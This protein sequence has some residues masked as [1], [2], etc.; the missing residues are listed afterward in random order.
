ML[1]R[2]ALLITLLTVLAVV[3]PASAQLVSLADDLALFSRILTSEQEAR[4]HT[5]LG[6]G[7]GSLESL[8][9][10]LPG[11][12]TPAPLE[13][14]RT[15]A[16]GQ[17]IITPIPSIPGPGSA[18]E[19][20]ALDLPH[21]T[22]DGPADGLTLEQAMERLLQTNY[23]L[24]TRFQELSKADADILTA[25]LR[26]NPLLFASA[27]N[28]PYGSYSPQ[29][30]GEALYSATIIQSLDL[31]NKRENRL[32]VARSARNVLEALYQN[33]VRQE[34]DNLYRA[35]LEVLAA[36]ETLRHRQAGLESL[37]HDLALLA[38][39]QKP[40]EA[41]ESVEMDRV[42]MRRDAAVM[43][44]ESATAVLRQAQQ[45]LAALLN[46]PPEEASCLQVRGRLDP[47]EV[48]LPC[49]E[50]LI[51]RAVQGRPD[52]VAYR[53]GIRR[54]QAE[55]RLARSERF[56]DVFVLYTPY[57]FQDNGALGLQNASSWSLGG[58][59][60]LP[61]FDRNE[62][63]IARAR[64]AV[65]Q[66]GLELQ[67]REREVVAEVQRAYQEYLT[68]RAAVC[69]FQQEILPR[70]Q[71]A[72]AEHRRQLTLNRESPASFLLAEKD[73]HDIVHQYLEAL[74]HER[75]SGY[76]LNTVVG[77]RLLP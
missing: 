27:S 46:L 66:T 67:A 60:T 59:V 72:R 35:F 6:P 17:A 76:H 42:L 75:R 30:P 58:M 49:V 74:I 1:P 5:H 32:R 33:A 13:P 7:P 70:A 62:G 47:R 20:D 43:S 61:L 8:F 2:R 48:P 15:R 16:R 34:I 50:A 73:Y 77:E 37:Q 57:Q 29:R 56:E 68:S 25:G 14:P 28:L 26:S 19:A 18:E 31:N 53:L 24:R 54:A 44:V 65:A 11:E 21:A 39:S 12:L 63:N 23:D 9:P 22:E 52:L 40:G 71:R 55:L 36:R 45:T 64:V 4:R 38:Q 69:R 3:R 10:T 51:D 41:Q